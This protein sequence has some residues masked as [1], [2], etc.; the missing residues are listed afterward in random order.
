[1]A[2]IQIKY[3]IPT[4]DTVEAGEQ[5]IEALKSGAITNDHHEIYANDLEQNYRINQI[6]ISASKD[7]SDKAE[8]YC[9]GYVCPKCKDINVRLKSNYCHNCGVKLIWIK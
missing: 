1:M 3:F 7:F 9:N 8:L 6:D 4:P 2:K 5:F